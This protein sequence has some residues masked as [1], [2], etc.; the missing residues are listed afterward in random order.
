MALETKVVGMLATG[1]AYQEGMMMT[2]MKG[3]GGGWRTVK[4]VGMRTGTEV[5]QQA[6]VL[7]GMP[8]RA[9]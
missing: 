5:S 2:A 1:A 9:A 6:E 7:M 4:A 3:A 8:A